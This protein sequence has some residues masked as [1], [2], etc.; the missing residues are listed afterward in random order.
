MEKVESKLT[1]HTYPDHLRETMQEMMT[2]GDFTDVT[3]VSDDKISLKAHRNILSAC[4]PVFKSILQ[5]EPQHNHPVIY[6]RGTQHSQI[7]SILQFIYLGEATFHEK[8]IDD[9][10]FLGK[11]LQI[12]ELMENAEYNHNTDSKFENNMAKVEY[13]SKVEL[14]ESGMSK[15][16]VEYQNEVEVEQGEVKYQT[17]V[18]LQEFVMSKGS[19]H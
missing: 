5:L 12:K 3:L 15:S 1:W 19:L 9:F 8:T 4:S 14:Q 13:Q 7:E 6:L 2:S 16:N 18:E 17:K 11:D 10:M